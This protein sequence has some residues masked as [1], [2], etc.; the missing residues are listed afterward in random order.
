MAAKTREISKQLQDEIRSLS[1]SS[2]SNP[3]DQDKTTADKATPSSTVIKDEPTPKAPATPLALHKRVVTL[4]YLDKFEKAT[5]ASARYE[6]IKDFSHIISNLSIILLAVSII[7]CLIVYFID[8][9]MLSFIALLGLLLEAFALLSITIYTTA[10]TTTLKQ[11]KDVAH[12][13]LSTCIHIIGDPRS[14]DFI[15][16]PNTSLT[17]S[18]P[19]V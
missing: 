14:Q 11:I 8:P 10:K 19:Q 9:Q 7:I 3:V 13:D 1:F 6:A 15:A 5:A 17:N 18:K 4:E 16:T 12:S 2:E